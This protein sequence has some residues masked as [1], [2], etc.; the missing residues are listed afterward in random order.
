ML[1]SQEGNKEELYIYL[2]SKDCELIFPEN[3]AWDFTI[4]LPRTLHLDG[5]WLCA[6]MQVEFQVGKAKTSKEHLY[7]CCGLSEE[8]FI[9][10]TQLPVLNEVTINAKPNLQTRD[11][12]NPRYI[13]L[14]RGTVEEIRVF[15]KNEDLQK[16]SLLTGCL[17]CT[18]HL[19]KRG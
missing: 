15:I 16:P 12:K 14:S 6:L 17:K 11:F 19:L 7:I 8:S 3:K 5:K 18:L 2:S 1:Y 9:R 4:R 10:G 13:Q